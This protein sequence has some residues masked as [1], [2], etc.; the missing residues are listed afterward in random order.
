M[1]A[2]DEQDQAALKAIEGALALPNGD[3]LAVL[4]LYRVQC[5][6][7]ARKEERE[8]V[9]SAIEH[10]FADDAWIHHDAICDVVASLRGGA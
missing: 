1:T 9:L 5:E 10:D 2:L 7:E 6:L 3:A 4:R 8:R